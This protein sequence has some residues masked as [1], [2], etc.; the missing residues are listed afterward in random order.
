M[1]Y[2]VGKPQ[3]DEERDADIASW[4][5]LG[6]SH[7]TPPPPR[8]P[9]LCE[10]F[11]KYGDVCNSWSA[12]RVNGKRYCAIHGREEQEKNLSAEGR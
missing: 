6:R 5:N 3:T 9:R 1:I 12:F 4:N 2:P 7:L 10:G 8:D 11:N